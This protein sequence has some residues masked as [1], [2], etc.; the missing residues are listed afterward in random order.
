[1]KSQYH[2][3]LHKQNGSMQRKIF[4]DWASNSRF[5]SFTRAHRTLASVRTNLF[6]SWQGEARKLIHVPQRFRKRY[7]LGNLY[8]NHSAYRNKTKRKLHVPTRSLVMLRGFALDRSNSILGRNKKYEN[9]RVKWGTVCKRCCLRIIFPYF[10][11]LNS[12]SFYGNVPVQ[13]GGREIDS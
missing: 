12:I 1:M 2:A 3:K 5:N 4:N 8:V 10:I 13:V 7:N 9:G 11:H 6:G